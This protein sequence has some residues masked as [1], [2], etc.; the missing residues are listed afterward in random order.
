VASVQP[1]A[2]QAKTLSVKPKQFNQP[3]TLAAEG[4]QGAAE[5]AFLQHLL[6]QHRQEIL[7]EL[8]YTPAP[9]AAVSAPASPGI[10]AV[11]QT[12]NA[13]TMSRSDAAVLA[14]NLPSAPADLKRFFF[15]RQVVVGRQP[16]GQIS[17]AADDAAEI[18]INGKVLGSIGSVTDM[19]EAS[20]ASSRLTSFDLTPLLVA[21]SN[22]ITIAAQNGPSTYAG[23]PSSCAYSGNPA[24]VVFGGQITWGDMGS[25]VDAGTTDAAALSPDCQRLYNC[26]VGPAAQTAQ[27]CTGL[28]AQ[29]ICGVWLQSYAMAG[30]RCAP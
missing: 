6:G 11:S 17:V 28:V 14:D 26:C 10:G 20:I 30:I 2:E 18:R 4:E 19:S 23:C 25:A 21:G 13:A 9:A 3:A 8:G 16:R 1:F 15:S 22:T 5:R 27:F 24:G 29:G 7:K 12:A